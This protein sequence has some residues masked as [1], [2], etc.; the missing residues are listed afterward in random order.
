MITG[1]RDQNRD[2]Y[3]LL[4]DP[5]TR[6]TH[7]FA[8]TVDDDFCT[9]ESITFRDLRRTQQ[10]PDLFRKFRANSVFC[11]PDAHGRCYFVKCNRF[12][13]VNSSNAV[14]YFRDDKQNVIALFRPVTI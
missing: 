14:T 8:E 5:R 12:C 10:K 2:F 4:A 9:C 1:R 7:R 13:V 6:V 11:Y 3:K